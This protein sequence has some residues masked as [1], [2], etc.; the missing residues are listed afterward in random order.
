MGKINI[1]SLHRYNQFIFPTGVSGSVC[2]S[3]QNFCMIYSTVVA[4]KGDCFLSM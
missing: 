2:Y 1:V 4:L 3:L